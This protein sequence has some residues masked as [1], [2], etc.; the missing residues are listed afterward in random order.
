MGRGECL[1]LPPTNSPIKYAG[2]C[3]FDNGSP[4]QDH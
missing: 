2:V 4:P 1:K 3:L